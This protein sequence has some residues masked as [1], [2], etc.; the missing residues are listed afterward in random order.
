MI[1]RKSFSFSSD[2]GPLNLLLPLRFG[3]VYSLMRDGDGDGI[4]P[5]LKRGLL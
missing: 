2:Y 1:L 3:G 5:N 4:L